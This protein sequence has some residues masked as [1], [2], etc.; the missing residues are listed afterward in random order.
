[1]ETRETCGVVNT[2]VNYYSNYLQSYLYSSPCE[3][4]KPFVIC[5]AGWWCADRSMLAYL[6]R[7]D[8]SSRLANR[9]VV[10]LE[11]DFHCKKKPPCFPF[12]EK[13]EPKM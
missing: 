12:P 2:S 5:R 13:D 3:G 1:M 11:V 7:G 8:W 9:D 4:Q 6:D 10:K